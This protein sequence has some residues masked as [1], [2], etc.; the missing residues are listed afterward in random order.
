MLRMRMFCMGKDRLLCSLR[1]KNGVR[2]TPADAGAF[3]FII[4]TSWEMKSDK[5]TRNP[6]PAE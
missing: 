6:I 3:L 4:V 2:I 1:R 5:Q